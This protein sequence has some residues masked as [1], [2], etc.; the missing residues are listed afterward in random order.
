MKC[1][2]FD[3]GLVM[4]ANNQPRTV[5][6]GDQVEL[7]LDG[8]PLDA[9]GIIKKIT[10]NEVS[11]TR[12]N[13]EVIHL[14]MTPSADGRITAVQTVVSIKENLQYSRDHIFGVDKRVA[15]VQLTFTE[16]K[17]KVEKTE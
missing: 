14:A 6:V 15:S 8:Q 9:S 5:S 11:I 13:G 12:W 7:V 1:L 10:K 17:D 16:D 3:G 2:E 4:I